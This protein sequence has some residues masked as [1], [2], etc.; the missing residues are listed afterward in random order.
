[1][2]SS[3]PEGEISGWEFEHSKVVHPGK[4]RFRIP[5]ASFKLFRLSDCGDRPGQNPRLL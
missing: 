1:M 4:P 2:N 3:N 5:S